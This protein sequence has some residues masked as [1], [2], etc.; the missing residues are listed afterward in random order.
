MKTKKQ[1][2]KETKRPQKAKAPKAAGKPEA[3]PKRQAEKK[4]TIRQ[5]VAAMFA[6]NAAVKNED[7]VKAVKEKFP[8]SAFDS[9]HASWYRQQAKNGKLT[10][11]PIVVPP[12]K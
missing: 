10:G 11:T 1:Q 12:A 6:E 4:A 7:L 2:S 9:K 3:A 5:L 8:E